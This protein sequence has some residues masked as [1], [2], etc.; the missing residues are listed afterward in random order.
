MNSETIELV[1]DS[2]EEVYLHLL[3]LHLRT[4][5]TINNVRF[6]DVPRNTEKSAPTVSSIKQNATKLSVTLFS[7]SPDL[8]YVNS[9][10]NAPKLQT[11]VSRLPESKESR[12]VSS[13]PCPK[14]S[15]VEDR[16]LPDLS[17]L[18][19]CTLSASSASCLMIY[20]GYQNQNVTATINI[21]TESKAR[22]VH[23]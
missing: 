22:S 14:A 5:A 6:S 8:H 20:P 9:R 18:S 16:N 19:N 12:F 1:A 3:S 10:T 7:K 2:L 23:S 17:L 13:Y 21:G 15:H 11:Q 4:L